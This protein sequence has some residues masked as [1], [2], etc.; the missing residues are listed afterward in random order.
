MKAS[1]RRYLCSFLARKWAIQSKIVKKRAI[2]ISLVEKYN[3]ASR[4]SIYRGGSYQCGEA[5]ASAKCFSVTGQRRGK[6]LGGRSGK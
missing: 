2:E 1:G 6:A 3:G 4:V 5:K